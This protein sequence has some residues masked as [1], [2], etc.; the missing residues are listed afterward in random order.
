[1]QEILL[2]FQYAVDISCQSTEAWQPLGIDMADSVVVL[3]LL[4][5]FDVRLPSHGSYMLDA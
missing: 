4:P 5:R 3:D 2:G 1:M